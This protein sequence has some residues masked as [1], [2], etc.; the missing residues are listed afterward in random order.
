MQNEDKVIPLVA[1]SNLHPVSRPGNSK[2]I[3]AH[4][5]QR[6][7]GE[8][9]CRVTGN[10]ALKSEIKI[11]EQVQHRIRAIDDV[12]E[13]SVLFIIYLFANILSS[14]TC[15]VLSFSSFFFF[16]LLSLFDDHFL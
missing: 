3:D 14:E 8:Q 16:S 4:Q 6:N 12:D 9:L 7:K 1:D 15:F 11:R 13:I 5:I 10:V 2:Q